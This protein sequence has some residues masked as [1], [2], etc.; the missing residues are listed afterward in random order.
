MYVYIKKYIYI[1]IYVYEAYEERARA[2]RQ[3]AAPPQPPKTLVII[4]WHVSHYLR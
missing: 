1:C 3:A 2:Y 4:I